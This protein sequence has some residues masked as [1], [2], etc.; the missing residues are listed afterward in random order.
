[1]DPVNILLIFIIF[2]VLL[3]IFLFFIAYKLFF[4]RSS[5]H[6]YSLI[7]DDVF[8][9]GDVPREFIND[10]ETLN[11]LA[12]EFDFTNLSPEEQQS[13]LRGEEFSKLTP[14]NFS[15]T[16]GKSYTHEDDLIIK[17]C[18]LNAFEFEQD[19]EILDTR[20]IVAD[21]TEIHFIHND[22]PYSTATSV[23][24]YSLPVKNRTYSDIIYF[25]T[26]VFEFDSSN[27]NGHFAIGLVTKP[28][29]SSFRLPGYNNFSI[30]Y[31]STG[32]LK[33]NKPF[34]TPLQQHMD[35]NSKFNAQVLPP[36]QQSDV[37]GFGYVVSTGTIFITRNGKKVMDVIKD[38]F[39]DLYPAVGCFL[40]NAKFQVNIGQLGYVWIEANV[41]KYG[42]ISTSDYKKIGGDRGL[43]SLPQYG[44]LGKQDGDKLLDKGEELPPD[45]PE[46]ELDFFGRSTKDIVRFGSSSKSQGVNNEKNEELDDE[47]KPENISHSVITDEPE[48]IMD[49]RERLYEQNIDSKNGKSSENV[50]VITSNVTANY[51]SVNDRSS[52]QHKEPLEQSEEPSVDEPAPITNVEASSSTQARSS[53]SGTE[54]PETTA[55]PEPSDPVTKTTTSSSKSKKPKKKKKSGKKKSKRK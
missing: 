53:D 41:R 15:N 51:G 11:F 28:Y 19:Q 27:E 7:G 50:P 48:E 44:E 17:D 31:E 6:D 26:K 12:D 54:S 33:I 37:V 23:L 36:L 55:S 43:A 32:N 25:E 42:F 46:D 40:T 22:T 14:P 24:N 39:I 8:G 29:P 5:R 21:K 35:V 10:E 38:C 34:P 52:S 16:R 30:A 49:L 9:F 2:S 1:M 3:F 47:V 4:S 20:Y 13:Y 45:Y 18:G